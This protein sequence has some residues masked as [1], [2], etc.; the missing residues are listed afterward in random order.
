M[1][2]REF[3]IESSIFPERRVRQQYMNMENTQEKPALRLV[4]EGVGVE[5]D[6]YTKRFTST[7]EETRRI[8]WQVLC[9]DFLQ[10]Y[11]SENDVV[12]DIGAGDGHFLKNIKARR[13][14]AVDLSPH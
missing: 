14:I 8:T 10:Q 9:R 5:E 4:G 6:I 7:Q 2:S 1:P 12:V 13:R 3:K 11:V